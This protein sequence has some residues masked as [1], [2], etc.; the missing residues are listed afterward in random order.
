VVIPIALKT[1]TSRTLLF[2]GEYMKK[3]LHVKK[4][5]GQTPFTATIPQKLPIN[6][7][8]INLLAQ[9]IHLI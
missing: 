4:I 5:A 8:P 1:G 2:K 3:A 6:L 7:L 9:T